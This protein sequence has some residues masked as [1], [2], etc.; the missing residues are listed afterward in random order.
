MQVG[1]LE[2]QSS[3]SESD[4]Q[5]AYIRTLEIVLHTLTIKNHIKGVWFT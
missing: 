4:R 3:D 1:S 5:R 2:R